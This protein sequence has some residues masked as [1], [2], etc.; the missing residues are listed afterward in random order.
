MVTAFVNEIETNFQKLLWVTRDRE[1]VE[2]S[3]AKRPRP[4]GSYIYIVCYLEYSLSRQQ[5][6]WCIREYLRS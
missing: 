4:K 6:D 1:A 2:F 5:V 3:V